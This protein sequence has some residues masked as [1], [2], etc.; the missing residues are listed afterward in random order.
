MS[1]TKRPRQSSG[2][3][4]AALLVLGLAHLDPVPAV[5]ADK[6]VVAG[7]DRY[8]LLHL[9]SG[10]EVVGDDLTVP[11][12]LPV[13]ALDVGA[14]RLVGAG[15]H[16]AGHG[17]RVAATDPALRPLPYRQILRAACSQLVRVDVAAVLVLDVGV[18]QVGLAGPCPRFRVGAGRADRRCRAGLRRRRLTLCRLGDRRLRIGWAGRSDRR[19]P[20]G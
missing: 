15:F 14:G 13:T 6:C 16:L 19:M 12:A 17:V 18:E 10:D 8:P 3:G 1:T 9:R 2:T 20:A 7:P 11:A 5:P 4:G